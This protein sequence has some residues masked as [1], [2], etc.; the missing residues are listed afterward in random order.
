M[1]KKK[2]SK[3]DRAWE[4]LFD[5]HQILDSIKL[6]GQFVITSDQIKIVREPRL[7]AKADTSESLPIIFKENNLGILPISRNSYIISSVN[8]YQDIEPLSEPIK[9]VVLPDFIQSIQ[10]SNINTESIAL[11][12]AFATKIFSDFLD[13]RNPY[14]TVSGRMGSGKF[15][16]KI[17]DKVTKQYHKIEVENSQIEIDMAIEGAKS[18]SL[19]E[20]KLFTFSNFLIRQVYY[21]FRTWKNKLDKCIR[22]IF[23]VYSNGIFSLYEY[24][25][26]DVYNYNSLYLV[27]GARYSIEDTRITG[28]EVEKIIASIVHVPEPSIP[29]PQ[30]D[31]FDR[32]VDL[33]FVLLQHDLDLEEITEEYGFDIRQ[34]SYYSSAAMY[35]G[36]VEKTNNTGLTQF[37]LTSRGSKIF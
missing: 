26:D 33:C 27:K 4:I 14:A 37:R 7:M 11:N 34:A 31:K 12:T 8:A 23:F 6:T 32:V 36:L 5:K 10:P 1:S 35:L 24:A 2:M 19:I 13:E 22:N 25:F 21:P 3:N 16:F 17:Q 20:A 30:A 29:F 15:K 9:H 18:L 28:L